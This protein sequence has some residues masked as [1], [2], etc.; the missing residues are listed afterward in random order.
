M[1]FDIRAL[2]ARLGG[3][4]FFLILMMGLVSGTT[5]S[6]LVGR[7]GESDSPYVTVFRDRVDLVEVVAVAVGTGEIDLGFFLSLFSLAFAILAAAA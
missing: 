5:G 1:V 3:R 2:E 6:G 7:S 4:G